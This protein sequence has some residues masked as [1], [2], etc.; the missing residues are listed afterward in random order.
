MYSLE[1]EGLILKRR[2]AETLIEILT[3]MT[4]FGVMIAGISEFMANQ[5]TNVAYII[6]RDEMMYAVQEYYN[7]GKTEEINIDGVSVDK[8]GDIIIASKDKNNFMTF[9]LK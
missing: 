4:V 6:K 8:Q 7:E 9:Q 1:T 2:K 3:A 5:T